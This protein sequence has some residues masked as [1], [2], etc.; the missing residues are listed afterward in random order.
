M[1]QYGGFIPFD[2]ISK[3]KRSKP[4]RSKPKRSKVKRRDK[5]FGSKQTRKN[6]YKCENSQIIVEK[7]TG[8]RRCSTNTEPGIVIRG[9]D[10]SL[11]ILKKF[12]SIKKWVKI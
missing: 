8:K 11:Y 2:E 3:L 4:K 6:S 5:K 10:D 7:E 9:E 12:K 1:K